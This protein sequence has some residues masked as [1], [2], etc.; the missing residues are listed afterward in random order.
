MKTYRYRVIT[1]LSKHVWQHGKNWGEKGMLKSIC[2]L[3]TNLLRRKM[4][5][6]ILKEITKRKQHLSSPALK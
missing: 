5:F 6:A 1:E 2:P 3:N 4:L